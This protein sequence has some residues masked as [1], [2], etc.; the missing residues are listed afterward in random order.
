MAFKFG[1]TVLQKTGTAAGSVRSRV[2][3]DTINTVFEPK[4]TTRAGGLRDITQEAVR[5]S[6]PGSR[7]TDS[8]FP[9]YLRN[10]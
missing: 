8:F 2:M 9:D 1:T 10:K 6:S 3:V 4:R 7:F 5:P